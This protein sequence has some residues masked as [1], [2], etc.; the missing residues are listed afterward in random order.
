M[1]SNVGFMVFG[2]DRMLANVCKMLKNVGNWMS[3]MWSNVGLKCHGMW[4]ISSANVIKCYVMCWHVIQCYAVSK[5]V[6]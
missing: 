4:G 5:N 2:G 1:L 6:R 3:K